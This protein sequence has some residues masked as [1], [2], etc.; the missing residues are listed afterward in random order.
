ML[1]AILICRDIG[2]NMTIQN[3][4]NFVDY[5]G[6]GAQT[7]FAFN[8]RVADITWVDVDFT[9]DISGVS[10]NIDQDGSPGGTVDYLVAPPNLQDIHIQRI[11]PITQETNY[12]RHDPFDSETNEDNLDK[13]TSII[14]DLS[15]DLSSVSAAFDQLWQFADFNANRTLQAFDKSKMLRAIGIDPVVQ[16][17]TIPNDSN[18]DHEIGTQIS[19][20]RKGTAAVNWVGEGGVVINTP[21][22]SSI[23]RQFGTVTF[24]KEDSNEWM[25]VGE[26]LEV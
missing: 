6:N 3:V 20:Y 22:G 16:L 19:V 10:L 12:S 26:I 23:A 11:T 13:I 2:Y 18:I 8:F 4:Q 15:A 25:V 7:S 24:I 5:T 14:Q 21:A 17:V 1:T 9:D